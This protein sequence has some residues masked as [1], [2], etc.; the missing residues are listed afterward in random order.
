MDVRAWG[1]F[2]DGHLVSTGRGMT[3]AHARRQAELLT[4]FNGSHARYRA[5]ALTPVIWVPHDSD[6][7]QVGGGPR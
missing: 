3:E 6:F 2:R 1:V 4:A 7:G 5:D